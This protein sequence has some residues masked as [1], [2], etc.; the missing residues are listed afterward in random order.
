MGKFSASM[1]R[2]IPGRMTILSCFRTLFRVFLVLMSEAIDIS[3]HGE[4]S[5][6]VSL[7]KVNRCTRHQ[8][9]YFAEAEASIFHG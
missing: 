8:R 1:D 9:Q 6:H 7:M 2:C 4:L 3:S 5:K